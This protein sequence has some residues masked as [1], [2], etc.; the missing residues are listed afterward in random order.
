[1]AR[2]TNANSPTTMAATI[3]TVCLP[4]GGLH[5]AAEIS[6]I[7]FSLFAFPADNAALEFFRHGFPQLVHEDECGLV[8]EDR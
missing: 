8:G 1:M 5:I 3:Q 2:P 6:A 4:V 7:Y